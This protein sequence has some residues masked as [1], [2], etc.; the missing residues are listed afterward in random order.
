MLHHL[1]PYSSLFREIVSSFFLEGFRKEASLTCYTSHAPIMNLAVSSPS[2]SLLLPFPLSDT[3]VYPIK[4]AIWV[5]M[6]AS[7]C[8]ILI[9][10]G[11]GGVLGVLS[12]CSIHEPIVP[13]NTWR[14]SFIVITHCSLTNRNEDLPMPS[15]TP[16]GRIDYLPKG[17]EVRDS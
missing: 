7:D 17:R 4:H 8:P 16:P 14:C 6:L 3:R 12:A 1:S 11:R 13:L 15:I 2:S 9:Q 5:W 10:T